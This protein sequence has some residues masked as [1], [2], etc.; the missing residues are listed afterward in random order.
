[1]CARGGFALL[2]AIIGVGIAALLTFAF[3]ASIAQAERSGAAA[4]DAMQA[5][6]LL[7]EAYEVAYAISQSEWSALDPAV[8]TVAD[9]CAPAVVGGVWTLSAGE[10]TVGRFT[11][12][13]AVEPA[14]RAT[15]A[16]FAL[17]ETGGDAD[18]DTR[19]VTATVSW[20]FRGEA[21]TET[22]DFYVYAL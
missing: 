13:L 7:L 22:L 20:V 10:E 3:L 18:P 11:R 5:Q 14:R 1:M 2:D 19:K 16:P 17:V 8:C 4:R 6:L 15:T 9:P 12:G 21:R